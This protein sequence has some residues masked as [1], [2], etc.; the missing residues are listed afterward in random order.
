MN[1]CP[2]CNKF[3]SMENGEP[4]FNSLEAM[5]QNGDVF[6]TA[7]VRSIRNCADCGTEMKSLDVE[8]EENISIETFDGF[9]ELS[10]KD[11][12]K[13]LKFAEEEDETL[14]L[15]ADEGDTSMDE[16]GGGRYKKNMITTVARG[17]ITLTWDRRAHGGEVKLTT[18]VELSSE[19]AA[20]EF[21]ECC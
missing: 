11:K 6:V 13:L 8:M 5:L 9:K 19:N 16:S 12:A 14:E 1:R 10:D 3:V 17:D 18:T 20:S 2:D 4:E 15:E 7:S 21:E